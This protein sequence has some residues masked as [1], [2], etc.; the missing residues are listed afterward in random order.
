MQN[1]HLKDLRLL[2]AVS[3]NTQKKALHVARLLAIVYQVGGAS[4]ADQCAGEERGR[5]PCNPLQ[6][7]YPGDKQTEMKLRRPWHMAGE[8]CDEATNEHLD[9]TRE[10]TAILTKC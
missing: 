3:A 10:L 4:N 6:R 2:P 1:K 8:A 9:M 7:I 5:Y